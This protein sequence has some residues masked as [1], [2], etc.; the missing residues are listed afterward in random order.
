MKFLEKTF[1][2][3]TI[4]FITSLLGC[5]DAS[6]I[7]IDAP[8]NLSASDITSDS[9]TLSWSEVYGSTKYSIYVNSEND[10]SSSG[11]LG[12]VTT[13]GVNIT[14]LDS[15]T[16]Y[17]FWVYANSFSGKG[18]PSES[19]HIT[20]VIGCPE[21]FSA[22]KSTSSKITLSWSA[23][24]ACDYYVLYRST[25]SSLDDAE[26]IKEILV[27]NTGYE[28]IEI[29][30]SEVE[31]TGGV[32]Y[33]WLKCKKDNT[34]STNQAFAYCRLKD[35]DYKFGFSSELPQTST[36]AKTVEL[37]TKT[38]TMPSGN[39]VF[40]FSTNPTENSSVYSGAAQI[41]SSSLSNSSVL[42]KFNNDY[43]VL[44]MKNAST[45]TRSSQTS[46]T[47]KQQLISQIES[48]KFS[49]INRIEKTEVLQF[50]SENHDFKVVTD[51]IPVSSLSSRSSKKLSSVQSE[52]TS[53]SYNVND[54]KSFYVD[55]SSGNFNLKTAILKATS[56]NCN[57]WILSDN[58][59]GSSASDSDNKLTLSQLEI[60][61]EKFEVI[62]EPETAIFGS[63]YK[64]LS[65]DIS[66]YVPR[67][68]KINILVFDIE[69]DFSPF[70]TSGTL[71]YFWGK[72]MFY[73][74]VV[75]AQTSYRSNECEIF[76]IDS[77]FL[78]KYP[79]FVYSTL[80]HEFQHMLNFVHK[81]MENGKS[82]STWFNEML[83]MICEDLLSSAE[84]LD[85]DDQY[86][87]KSR[88]PYFNCGYALLGLNQWDSTYYA[89]AYANAYAF[90]AWLTRNYG[91]AELV[92]E[93]ALNDKIDL[94]CIVAA[95]E[96]V[97]GSTVT[98][99]E[100]LKE[101][102]RSLC[103]PELTYNEF[104][105]ATNNYSTN[106]LKPF[107]AKSTSS[108]TN[109]ST[110]NIF[111]FT[112]DSIQLSDYYYTLDDKYYFTPYYYSTEYRY[113]MSDY[114]SIVMDL[115]ATNKNT[116]VYL[117]GSSG[118]KSYLVVQ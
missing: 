49:P 9:C 52:E 90:G 60:L 57:I 86:S 13:N 64:D 62:Y 105:Y 72:D 21:E 40:F 50:N 20:T 27:G 3:C 74:S 97:T 104:N 108:I 82:S 26:A 67:S 6:T 29:S 59:D 51:S 8:Q 12:E 101:F 37:F 71:G 61:T 110:G 53:R 23:V 35:I 89:Y 107:C 34:E 36:S 80:A 17:Y 32:Y 109:S 113:S 31:S 118:T 77:Y 70:Q 47:Y 16:D 48:P 79:N 78:D 68:E 81:T 14:N 10:I 95:V 100:L 44:S 46:T 88:L 106:S 39:N 18:N 45:K 63:T 28:D 54:T 92:H 15:Y 66:G 43:S 98:V 41:Y 87:P 58:F 25:E 112:L 102:T 33:Y 69:D 73:D 91:G 83:S 11:L 22:S 5:V 94:D 7:L 65:A 103:Y 24:S 30:E 85:T 56:T 84:Y 99:Q 1:V 111:E 2:F 76:Y 75:K 19:V 38:G 96:T 4:F 117:S 55:D 115:G 116:A 93:M 42:S 114:G